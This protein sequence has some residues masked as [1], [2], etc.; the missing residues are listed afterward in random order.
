MFERIKEILIQYQEEKIKEKENLTANLIKL[1]SMEKELD[2]RFDIREQQLLEIRINKNSSNVFKRIFKWKQL[3]QD[4]D[5]YKSLIQEKL[6][7]LEKINKERKLI[8]D[9]ISKTAYNQIEIENTINRISSCSSFKQLGITEKSAIS[10]LEK[11]LSAD[12]NTISQVFLDIKNTMTIKTG[13]DIQKLMNKLYQVSSSVFVKEMNEVIPHKLFAKLSKKGIEVPEDKKRL[14]DEIFVF[15]LLPSTSNFPDLK[16][17]IIIDELDKNYI[18][19]LEKILT[20]IVKYPKSKINIVSFTTTLT[21][22][23]ELSK[24]NKEK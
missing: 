4:I 15:A 17:L 23:T 9:T 13:D 8:L 12:Y 20:M 11:H 21:I 6:P 2:K 24:T 7:E 19:E 5:L 3:K 18:N 22:L 16:E 14:I 10:L 1:D